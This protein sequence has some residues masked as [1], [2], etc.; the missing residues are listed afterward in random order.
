MSFGL[1][2]HLATK[3]E[4]NIRV[5][6]SWEGAGKDQMENATCLSPTKHLPEWRMDFVSWRVR[7][8][9]KCQSLGWY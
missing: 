7:C 1:T 5:P 2:L 6:D 8:L 4:Q 3:A 9:G